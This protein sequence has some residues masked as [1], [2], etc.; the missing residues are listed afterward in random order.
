MRTRNLARHCPRNA[1]RGRD[2][3]PPADA[4]RREGFRKLAAGIQRP[5]CRSALLVLR[6]V[7]HIVRQEMNRAGAQE[8]LMLF[9]GAAGGAVAGIRRWDQ[10]GPELL[11]LATATSAISAS[12]RRTRKSSP[13]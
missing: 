9:G 12:A 2:R 7:E 6:K 10:Y 3:Q 5:G 13:T 8:V 11:R 1:R 4:P